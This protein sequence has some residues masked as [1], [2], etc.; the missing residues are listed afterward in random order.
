MSSVNRITNG[1]TITVDVEQMVTKLDQAAG[2]L[3]KTLS[4]SQIALGL[5]VDGLDRLVNQQGK[6]VEGLSRAQ[7][8]M[9]MWVDELGRVRTANDQYVADLNRIEQALGMYATAEGKVINTQGQFVRYTAQATKAME[10]QKRAALEASEAQQRAELELLEAQQ[11]RTRNTSMKS[12]SS[13]LRKLTGIIS[14]SQGEIVRAIINA[15][16]KTSFTTAP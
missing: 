6:C 3:E 4:K 5:S 16:A 9:Q 15:V 12:D 11:T 7:I 13:F 10:A 1:D 2:R 14:R 8:R